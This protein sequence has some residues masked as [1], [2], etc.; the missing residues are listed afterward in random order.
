MY[1]GEVIGSGIFCFGA[2]TRVPQKAEDTSAPTVWINTDPIP[3]PEEHEAEV[4][5][6]GAKPPA[7]QPDARPTGSWQPNRTPPY[8]S[9]V[10][11]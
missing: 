11:W 1:P 10:D 3:S 5:V 8:H 7:K 6:S 4:E 9:M 2:M